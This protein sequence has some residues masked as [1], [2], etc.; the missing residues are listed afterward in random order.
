[1]TSTLTRPIV[2]ATT[3]SALAVAGGVAVRLVASPTS[4]AAPLP[5]PRVVLH[6]W[7]EA[8]ASA[9]ARGDVAALE[10][11]YARGSSA[12]AADVRSLRQWTARG[13]VVEGMERQVQRVRILRSTPRVLVLSVDDRLRAAVATSAQG[14]VRLPASR[15]RHW[16]LT[17]LRRNHGPDTRTWVMA[18]VRER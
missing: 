16:V 17:F 6:D 8:R 7:D 5:A 1:M 15:L 9:W 2:I 18:A 12:G 13:F 14:S 10:R 4:P 11:L 3:L